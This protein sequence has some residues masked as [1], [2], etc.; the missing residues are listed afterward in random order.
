LVLQT[1]TGKSMRAAILEVRL[2]ELGYSDPSLG[3]IFNDNPY[4]D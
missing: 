4:S 2:E 1:G 3:R